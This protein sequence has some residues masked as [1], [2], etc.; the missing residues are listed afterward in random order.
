MKPVKATGSVVLKSAEVAGVAARKSVT[1]SADT[2]ADAFEMLQAAY[3]KSL[4]TV[5]PECP[6][7]AFMLPTGPDTDDFVL[8]FDLEEFLDKLQTGILVRPKIELWAASADGHDVAHLSEELAVRFA[9]ELSAAMERATR[10]GQTTVAAREEL[11]TEAKQEVG[12]EL[13]GRTLGSAAFW[14]A[15]VALGAGGLAIAPVGIAGAVAVPSLMLAFGM[16]PRTA[17]FGKIG[18]YLRARSDRAT[19]EKQF[20]AEVK[21]L[22]KEFKR[23]RKTF[24]RAV[25]NLVIREHPRLRMASISFPDAEGKSATLNNPEVHSGDFPEVEQHLRHPLY[26]R[27]LAERNAQAGQADHS[28]VADEVHGGGVGGFFRRMFS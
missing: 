4:S 27:A 21:R 3:N 24:E 19:V 5:F 18:T 25:G 23:K 13:G 7:P 28:S 8:V 15:A 22:E 11:E 12:G 1:F 16:R 10:E 17:V 6:V 26:L 20:E 14:A 9:E 2:A